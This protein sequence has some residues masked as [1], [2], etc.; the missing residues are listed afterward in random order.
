MNKRWGFFFLFGGPIYFYHFCWIV[1]G[2]NNYCDITRNNICAPTGGYEESSAVFDGALLLCIIY[3]L[4]EWIR[5]TMF[6]TIPAGLINVMRGFYII[7]AI[8]I[9]YGIYSFI[10]AI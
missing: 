2:I 3:H 10:N 8:N 9:P 6:L 4:I 1:A 7:G 5:W